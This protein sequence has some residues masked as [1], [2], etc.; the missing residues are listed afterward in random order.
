MKVILFCGGL[1]MRMRP[2]APGAPMEGE[3]LPKPMVYIGAQRPLIWHVMKYY[4]HYGHQDF[5]LCLGHRAEVIKNY[6]LN[7]DECLT[8]DFVLS[9]GGKNVELLNNDIHDWRITFA[10]T[11]LKSCVGERF[12]AVKDHMD[13]E[14]IFLANYSDGISD[15]PLDKYLEAFKAS[16]K[17]AGCVCVHPQLTSHSVNLDA[18][19][20]I[21]GIEPIHTSDILING[22]Y[23]AFRK[24][25]YDYIKPGEEL[26]REPFQR[27]IA[28]NQLFGYRY[29]GFWMCVDTFKEKQEI[30]ERFAAGDTP[31]QVWKQDAKA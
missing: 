26:V 29:D 15:L 11:G 16:G 17:I 10:D 9:Q 18:D 2:L 27:L 6:F 5:V 14:D 20:S 8:N 13:G 19:G 12:L 22:G 24:E 1:G 30:D 23:F 4:A 25:I 31:W 28:D 3:D 7:Y 21:R